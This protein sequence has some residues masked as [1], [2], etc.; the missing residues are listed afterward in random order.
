MPSVWRE[1]K[2]LIF[3]NASHPNALVDV[4]LSPSADYLAVAC[5]HDVEIWDLKREL[6]N[7][8][9]PQSKFS[10]QYL[11][12]QKM[13][14]CPS[15]TKLAIGYDEG[16]V[17]VLSLHDGVVLMEGFGC[18][19]S[20][21]DSVSGLTWLSPTL[22]AVST[23]STVE[24][25]RFVSDDGQRLWSSCGAI[26]DPPIIPGQP[27]MPLISTMHALADHQLM[28]QYA[29]SGGR[30]VIWN[31]SF[32][33]FLARLLILP[34]KLQHR[35]NDVSISTRHAL[36]TDHDTGTYGLLKI[37]SQQPAM[38]CYPQ[39]LESRAPQLVSCVKFISKDLLI[40]GGVGQ[41]ILWNHSLRRLQN[42]VYTN[43]ITVPDSIS[44]GYQLETD[45]G[46]IATAHRFQDRGQVVLWC[47]VD[48]E[49]AEEAEE[50]A[51]A[52][53]FLELHRRSITI[54]LSLFIVT[55]VPFF[56]Y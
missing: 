24:I 4:L 23:R 31:L 20:P 7:P 36:Y 50:A 35:I 6:P 15:T 42:L 9:N 34:W 18:A 49:E 32:D 21:V 3:A 11:R 53:G 22:L 14:W 12:V 52:P 2:T 46:W 38:Q 16:S 26:P 33:P 29:D 55:A 40:G 41:L 10:N 48:S 17:S 37:D 8:D 5:G 1:V 39:A 28:V 45:I 13:S 27:Q 30:T 43:P 51:V 44:S 47:T 19:A 54:V 56:L 25:W